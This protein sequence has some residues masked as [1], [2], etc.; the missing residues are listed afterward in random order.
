MKRYVSL[1]K[2]TKFKK[3]NKLKSLFLLKKTNEEKEN[4]DKESNNVLP[5]ITS[6][7]SIKK[8]KD[9]TKNFVK[10]L[11]R[12]SRLSKIYEDY[13]DLFFYLLKHQKK[14]DILE[15]KS[16]KNRI[17]KKDDKLDKDTY[18]SESEDDFNKESNNIDINTIF[19]K[20]IFLGLIENKQFWESFYFP[21]AI[22][23]IIYRKTRLKQK[24]ILNFC[25]KYNIKYE[26][27]VNS[28]EKIY[29]IKTQKKNWDLE[30]ITAYN[31]YIEI[32]LKN[33]ELVKNK[34]LETN[35][36][37]KKENLYHY[38][39]Y[40]KFNK[41]IVVKTNNKGKGK[42]LIFDGK[43]LS[44]YVDDYLRKNND[45]YIISINSPKQKK[46]EI[47]YDAKDLL[48]SLKQ[49]FSFEKNNFL[50]RNRYNGIMTQKSN[51]DIIKQKLF[52]KENVFIR[53]LIFNKKEQISKKNKRKN[54]D[55]N[56]TN[57]EEFNK[58]SFSPESL[59]NFDSSNP[60]STNEN[61]SNLIL[62]K[63][64][65]K[66]K[67]VKNTKNKKNLFGAIKFTYY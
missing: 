21:K 42:T 65:N 19:Y 39:N 24:D 37:E 4:E 53:D 54:N 47:I 44:V 5:N 13:E 62:R 38:E 56:K 41:D 32:Y 1:L 2:G 61:T 3:N 18:E 48:P 23:K 50:N 45:N 30:P 16:N 25:Y 11:K 28:Y 36:N 52:K 46:K 35:A 6:S 29:T 34:E 27:V 17:K 9:D 12:K 57:Y 40:D 58:L 51:K 59:V 55:I 10:L 66:T 14:I 15:V 22:Y 64:I 31:N 43:L 67:L 26:K 33:E 63:I 7:K 49:S 20:K 8:G 60:L